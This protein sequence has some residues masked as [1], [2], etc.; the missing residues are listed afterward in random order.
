MP[1]ASAASSLPS[2]CGCVCGYAGVRL[3]AAVRSAVLRML[4]GTR[5]PTQRPPGCSRCLS[6]GRA[7]SPL[8]SSSL[9]TD[10][11]PLLRIF[12]PPFLPRALPGC[13]AARLP[14]TA[15]S[16]RHTAPADQPAP[17]QFFPSTCF[18]FRA[19]GPSPFTH[20][21]FHR[22]NTDHAHPLCSLSGRSCNPAILPL[23]CLLT[24][25]CLL[26]FPYPV[27]S[28]KSPACRPTAA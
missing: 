25:T 1:A 24:T 22:P 8:P 20:C 14:G 7:A 6:A 27:S 19:T 10:H 16:T 4:C 26:S 2:A 28:P 15:R 23:G 13:P 9:S 5:S 12:R 17:C 21:S 11:S 3:S 18:S